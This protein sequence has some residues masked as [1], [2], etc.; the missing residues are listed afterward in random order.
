MRI[1][2]TNMWKNANICGDVRHHIVQFWKCQN[3]RANTGMGYADFR[4]T[5]Y[6]LR[7]HDRY[8]PASLNELG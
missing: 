2:M 6:V 5:L 8:K 3:M 4:K 1:Y 7:S